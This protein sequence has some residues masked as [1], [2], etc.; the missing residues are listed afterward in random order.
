[1]ITILTIITVGTLAIVCFSFGVSVGQKT[2]KG[3]EIDVP[4][5]NPLK[6][7]EGRKNRKKA[8]EEADKLEKIMQNIET[9]DGTGNGQKDV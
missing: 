9:Y 2:A 3:E 8:E 5:F 7:Y 1:M 6:A 4:M